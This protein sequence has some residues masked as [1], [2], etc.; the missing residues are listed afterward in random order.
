MNFYIADLHIGDRR[1]LDYDDRPF[2]TVDEE[3]ETFIRNWNSVIQ[4]RDN[5]YILGDL[6]INN[7]YLD[8]VMPELGGIKHLVRGN[9]DKVTPAFKKYFVSIDNQIK[10]EDYGR[11]VTL[12][13]YPIVH[14]EGADLGWIHLYG[15]IHMGRDYL[16]FMKYKRELLKRGLPLNCYNVGC[17]LPYMNYTPQCLDIIIKEGRK[18]EEALFAEIKAKELA[19]KQKN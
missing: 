16:P 4:K 8:V 15:H 12:S 10:I 5:I 11:R 14:F 7:D 17:M 1:A 2:S 19:E 9:H 18:W 3:M 6:F 13:H